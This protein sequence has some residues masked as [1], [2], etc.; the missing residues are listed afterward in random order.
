MVIL[1]GVLNM[2]YDYLDIGDPEFVQKLV[3][4]IT[5]TVQGELASRLNR[6]DDELDHLNRMIDRTHRDI[7]GI[8]QRLDIIDE[9]VQKISERDQ[10]VEKVIEFKSIDGVQ[11]KNQIHEYLKNNP[12]SSFSDIFLELKLEPEIVLN[13]LNE[14]KDENRIYGEKIE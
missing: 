13:S 14:L 9:V 3:R 10:A 5:R 7:V 11:A 4:R 1:I 6:F 12:G 8:T 2:A